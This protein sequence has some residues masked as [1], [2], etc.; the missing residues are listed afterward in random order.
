MGLDWARSSPRLERVPHSQPSDEREYDR[1]GK[2]EL[3]HTT[4]T[5]PDQRGE[6]GGQQEQEGRLSV[7]SR[8]RRD[9]G[10]DVDGDRDM[11]EL[12]ASEQ[13]SIERLL[14][15]GDVRSGDKDI[16]RHCR[17]QS[18]CPVEGLE[19]PPPVEAQCPADDGLEELL[20][21]N[22][23]DD[24]KEDTEQGGEGQGL[25]EG[26]ADLALRN[27]PVESGEDDE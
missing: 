22:H 10:P 9:V 26:M 8:N 23:A 4:V 20:L 6:A 13:P 27:H 11:L 3:H 14:C 2:R 25:F 18:V 24:S 19:L 15:L 5:Q 21:V 12:L 1:V 16:V 17:E 7:G